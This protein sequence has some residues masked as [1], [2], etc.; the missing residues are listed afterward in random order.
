MSEKTEKIWKIAK[1]VL[2]SVLGAALL[3]FLFFVGEAFFGVNDDHATDDMG[4]YEAYLEDPLGARSFMPAEEEWGVYEKAGLSRRERI[5]YIFGHY[6]VCLFLQYGE[7][8]YDRQKQRIEEEYS[9]Y[10][11]PESCFHDVDGSIGGYRM[12][13]VRTDSSYADLKGGQF[14]GLNDERHTVLYAYYYDDDVDYIENM[15]KTLKRYFFIP[16]AWKS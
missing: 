1:I 13:I 7:E 6:S 5:Q 3:L 16:K 8:E 10:E 4:E 2:L 9:F 11:K 15:D 12:R 14:I